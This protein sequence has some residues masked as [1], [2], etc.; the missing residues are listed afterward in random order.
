MNDILPRLKDGTYVINLDDKK[1]KGTHWVPLFIDKNPTI[2]FD[3]FGIDYIPQ[4]VL[5]KIKDKSITHNILRIQD[6]NFIMCA[7]YCI[8]FLEYILVWKTLLDYTNLFLPNDN[9]KNDKIIYK[10]F[11]EKLIKFEI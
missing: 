11:K 3:S 4:E 9:K 8:T 6:N 5:S 2:Y 10:Y 7:F 1:T